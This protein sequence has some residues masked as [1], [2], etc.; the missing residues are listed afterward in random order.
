ME[1]WQDSVRCCHW[2]V[3]MRL[4]GASQ[5]TKSIIIAVND[6]N[7]LYLLRRYAEESG[8]E[9]ASAS[10]CKDVLSLLAQPA[11]PSLIILDS[12]LLGATARGPGATAR[13]PGA[14]A[15]KTGTH[16]LGMWHRLEVEAAARSI[17][18]VVYSYLDEPAAECHE[19]VS[20]CL[21]N[22]VMYD[23][24]LAAL[25]SAGVSLEPAFT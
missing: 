25:K 16:P 5:M 23:D 4:E 2:V 8:F 13:S 22:S 9:T 10:R 11:S 6:P 24:F 20:G 12:E 3:V 14:T 21:P 17:P 18:V 15:R 1:R 7:I 19:G